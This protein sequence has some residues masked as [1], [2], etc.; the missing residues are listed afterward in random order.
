MVRIST[1]SL[2]PSSGCTDKFDWEPF[3]KNVIFD[4]GVRLMY[5]RLEKGFLIAVKSFQDKSLKEANERR[6]PF[7]C[8]RSVKRLSH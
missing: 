7:C 8:H 1:P 5:V 4:T 6:Q 2:K 3:L